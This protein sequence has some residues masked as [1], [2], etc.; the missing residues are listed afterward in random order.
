MWGKVDMVVEVLVCREEKI[1]RGVG[2]GLHNRKLSTAGSILIQNAQ[3]KT[4]AL[5]G[6]WRMGLVK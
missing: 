3:I 2:F 5:E 4:R 6:V 1:G